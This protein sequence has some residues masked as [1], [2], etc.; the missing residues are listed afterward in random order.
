M[1]LSTNTSVLPTPTILS[2]SSSTLTPS[3]RGW[4]NQPDGRG[5]FDIIWSCLATLLICVWV[6]LH[7][8]VPAKEDTTWTLFLRKIRWL[9]LTILAPELLMLFASGQW[10]SAKRSVTEM[11]ELGYGKWSLV[12]AFYADSGGFLLCARDTIPFPVTAKQIYYLVHKKYTQMP[13][14]TREEIWDKSKAD[15]FAKTIAGLQAG[16]LVAQVIARALQQLPITLL[17]LSTVAL[18]TCTGAT[19]FF[20]FHKPLNVDTPT[21]LYLDLSMAEVLVLAGDEAST[22]FRDTPLDFVEPQLYTSSQMPLHRWWGVQQRP[23]PRIPNDRDSRLHNFQIVT[24]VALSTASFSLIHLAAWNFEFPTQ[25]EQILW[26]WTCIS[27]G[28]VLGIGCSV[29]AVSIIKDNFTTT[30][31]T[32]LN[33][34]KLKWPTNLL[35]F[36]PGAIYVFA[37]LIV[38]AEILIS[39]RLLPSGCFQNVQWMNLFPHF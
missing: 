24:I 38:I 29:E 28:V 21:T 4:V 16:W 12:H 15:K 5:T 31:L 22:P 18:I 6:M 36:I 14:I 3:K 32:N 9:G 8:N 39:L 7:L 23:L 27:M 37:R 20:W 17:E 33:G 13:A 2:Y 1:I 34:Y 35:F 30:G 26:R 19:F 10:A 11:G 25:I